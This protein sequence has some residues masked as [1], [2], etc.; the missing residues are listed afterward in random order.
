MTSKL[1]SA[2]SV[3]SFDARLWRPLLARPKPRF[4]L[5]GLV[6]GGAQALRGPYW[7]MARYAAGFAII[8]LITLFYARAV[9]ASTITV[10]FTFLL[11]ILSASTV[12]GL[13]V[14][15]MMSV[16]A[17]LA[18]DYFFL[19]PVGSLDVA[20]TR[21]WVA[22]CTFLVT[23]VLGS[24]LAARAQSRA[25]EANRRRQEVERL[26]ALS[27]R[28]LG[29]GDLLALSSA[30]PRHIVES[31]AVDSA[32]LFLFNNQQ[33]YR[34]GIPLWQFDDDNM[35]HAAIGDSGEGGQ[36]GVA[37]LAPLRL[38]AKVIGSLGVSG[39]MPSKETLGALGCLVAAAIE[40]ADANEHAAKMEVA[41][42]SEQ[43]KSVLLD[44]ITH[45][46][47]TPLTGIKA[48][49]TGLL[50][51]LEF[52]REQQKDLLLIIDE[53]CDRIDQL[54]ERAAEMAR[55]ESV[56]IK[57]VA[58]PHTIGELISTALAECRIVL[59]TRP[60]HIEVKHEESRV[61][62]DLLLAKTVLGHLINNADLYSS[63]G[64]P[65]TLSAEERNA[66]LF[67]SVAD[68][69]PGIEKTE[70]ALIFEKFYRGKD[71]RSRVNGTGMGLPIARAIAEAHGGT[72][73]VASRRGVGS[74]FT[75][76]LPLA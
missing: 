19:P 25:E 53:E 14:S 46:F 21:D 62:V 41:R 2:V 32:A 1:A 68:H 52:S 42:Q 29:E 40:R 75:F 61:L 23:A 15:S 56:K 36:H 63:P 73:S 26:Y 17:T 18:F 58:A 8:L 31:F 28:L 76:S 74:V 5:P 33:S 3:S 69:G 57:L 39:P 13:G 10:G 54:V 37:W 59:R 60:I 47:R 16:A 65:I 45:D 12:W 48:S 9:A 50:T 35:R 30:I 49:V 27:Q 11:A 43:F 24:S 22:L 71:Q 66:F 4:P 51:D 70:M 67:L 20:D 72:M 55:L 64:Q 44:A 6:R 34:T 7:L 38:G